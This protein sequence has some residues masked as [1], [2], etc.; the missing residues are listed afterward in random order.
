MLNTNNKKDYERL[1]VW[2]QYNDYRTNIVRQAT[3]N[4]SIDITTN[5]LDFET[6]RELHELAKHENEVS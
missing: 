2:L 5:I 4:K 6:W 3:E 1:T